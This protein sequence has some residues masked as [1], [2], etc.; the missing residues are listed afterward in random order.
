MFDQD[1]ITILG[2]WGDRTFLAQMM[3]KSA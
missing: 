2:W 1:D 3:A